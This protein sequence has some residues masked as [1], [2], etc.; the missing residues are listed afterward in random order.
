MFSLRLVCPPEQTE[1]ISAEL[2]EA[3]TAGIQEIAEP[4]VTVLIATFETNARRGELLRRFAALSPQWQA[5]DSTDW[6]AHTRDAWPARSV[7]E[8]LFLAPHWSREATPPGRTRI[9]HNPG[10]ACGTGEHPCTQLAL[11][12]IE[13]HLAPGATV[14]DIGTGSGILA[15]AALRLGAGIAI[16]ADP[17]EAALQAAHENFT[18]NRLPPLLVAGSADCLTNV[19]ADLVLANIDGPVLSS[20]L[21]DLVRIARP[22]GRLILTGFEEPELQIFRDRLGNGIVTAIGSWRCLAL[23][24]RNPL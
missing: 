17:D 15:I 2:W 5:A 3:E 14:A 24:Q 7:G 21:G 9:V 22:G 10:L 6:I 13:K 4:Q 16:G 19:C 12:A 18:L 20:I 1:T 11:A 8:R 23:E